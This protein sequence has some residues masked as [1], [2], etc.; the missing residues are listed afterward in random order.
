MKPQPFVVDP[1]DYP[2]TLNVVGEQ[3]TI[4]ASGAATQGYEVFLQQG[5]GGSGPPPH[6]H[7]WDETF[8]VIDGEVEFGL[9]NKRLVTQPGTLVHIPAGTTHWFRLGKGGAKMLSITARLA[10]SRMF[11]DISREISPDKPD[12]DKLVGVAARHGVTIL[13]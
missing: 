9:E 8:Y 12:L 4:L 2:K 7:P 10:A 5:P 6:A 1:K 13:A 11:A 3:I